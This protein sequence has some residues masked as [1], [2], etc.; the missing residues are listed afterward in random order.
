MH[1][2]Y[3]RNAY[4]ASETAK[5]QLNTNK[6]TKKQADALCLAEATYLRQSHKEDYYNCD[7]CPEGYISLYKSQGRDLGVQNGLL[8]EVTLE[9]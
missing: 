6:E 5:F 1:S 9:I 8:E 4:D 2:Q 7:N 3:L